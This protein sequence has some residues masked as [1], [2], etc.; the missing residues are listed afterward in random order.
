MTFNIFTRTIT[1]IVHAP[2]DG[3]KNKVFV[4]FKYQSDAG[5]RVIN[6]VPSKALQSMIC[7]GASIVL[8]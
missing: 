4:L 5:R 7:P 2:E 6:K 8:S 1:F 3:N